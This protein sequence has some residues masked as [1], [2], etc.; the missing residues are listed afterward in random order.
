MNDKQ[1]QT[2]SDE[3]KQE[4]LDLWRKQP[5]LKYFDA[6]NLLRGYFPEIKV[7]FAKEDSVPGRLELIERMLEGDLEQFKLKVYFREMY[8]G[9]GSTIPLLEPECVTANTLGY[10]AP[11]TD[12]NFANYWLYGELSTQELKG[13]LQGKGI[14][15]FFFE[16]ASTPILD[17]LNDKLLGHSG[18]LQKEATELAEVTVSNEPPQPP[19]ESML[20][21]RVKKKYRRGAISALTAANILGV[22][23]RQVQNWDAGIHR[24]DGYPGRRNETAFQLFASEWIR[25]QQLNKQARAM[26]QAVSDSGAVDRVTKSAFDED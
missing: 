7:Y 11:L 1:K 16:T 23:E 8:D 19:V 2:L 15:N 17:S 25:I 22:S 9:H 13:W 10:Y 18:T 24:P 26:N 6:L 5:Y 20:P 14:A 4:L 3:Q 21:I 12:N